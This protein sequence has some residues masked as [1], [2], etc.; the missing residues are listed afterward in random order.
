M[1]SELYVVRYVHSRWPVHNTHPRKCTVFIL[2]YLYCVNF[3]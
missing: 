3:R 2:R 1:F